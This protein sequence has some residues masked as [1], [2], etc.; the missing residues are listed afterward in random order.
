VKA[1]MLEG[2]RV[3]VS[4][5]DQEI[6]GGGW[7]ETTQLR[8]AELPSLALTELAGEVRTGGLSLLSSLLCLL[9]ETEQKY[10][11]LSGRSTLIT[12]ASPSTALDQL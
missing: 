6:A 7:P 2:R 10:T 5:W 1:V 9:E 11:P 8:E 3:P 4:V 12:A